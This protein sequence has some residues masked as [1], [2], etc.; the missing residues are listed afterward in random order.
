MRVQPLLSLIVWTIIFGL[1]V[2]NMVLVAIF[3]ANRTFKKF[4]LVG[5]GW[6]FQSSTVVGTNIFVFLASYLVSVPIFFENRTFFNF[7]GVGRGPSRGCRWSSP[8]FSF[9][10]P[11]LIYVPIFV[12]NRA[13]LNFDGV[14][15][16]CGRSG[17][18]RL[19]GPSFSFSSYRV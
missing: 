6:A 11:S 9:S 16:G 12:E 10:S 13:F 17:G 4:G 7:G 1:T 18:R 14:G 2:L 19:S 5:R 8:L 3:S 15:C